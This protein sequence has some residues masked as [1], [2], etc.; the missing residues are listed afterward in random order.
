VRESP[1]D[2]EVI[3][4]LVRNSRTCPLGQDIAPLQGEQFTRV[5]AE[6]KE[7]FDWPRAHCHARDAQERLDLPCVLFISEAGGE[8]HAV[9]QGAIQIKLLGDGVKISV[10]PRADVCVG[11]KA[12]ASWS[13]AAARLAIA[14]RSS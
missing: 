7:H 1:A 6:Y 9:K 2:C 4:E 14:L 3:S 11:S 13:F 5:F 12:K 10:S 8:V